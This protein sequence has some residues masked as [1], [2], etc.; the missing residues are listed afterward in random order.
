MALNVLWPL[1]WPVCHTRYGCIYSPICHTETA[2][3]VSD[4]LSHLDTRGEDGNSTVVVEQITGKVTS[5][6]VCHM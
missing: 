4:T 5:T 1:F 3:F 2:A 6:H